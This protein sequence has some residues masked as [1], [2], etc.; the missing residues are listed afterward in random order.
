M[1]SEVH[2]MQLDKAGIPYI[3]HICAVVA[4]C[5][6][7]MARVVAALHDVIEDCDDEDWYKSEI[8]GLFGTVVL[9]AVL[10]VTRRDGESYDDFIARVSECSIATE[11]KLADLR[12]NA[13][14]SR[15]KIPTDADHKRSLKYR[16]AISKLIYKGLD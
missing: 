12:H 8:E 2:S 14:L 9:D 16:R 15:L 10:R 7:P 5:K 6:T 4:G 13:D 11:V 1:A 3:A